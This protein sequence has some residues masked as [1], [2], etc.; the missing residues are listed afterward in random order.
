[1]PSGELRDDELSPATVTWTE[2]HS[3]TGW[4]VWLDEY[5]DE[6]SMF[7]G[8]FPPTAA[9]LRRMQMIEQSELD[10][11]APCAVCGLDVATGVG[12]RIDEEHVEVRAALTSDGP[13]HLECLSDQCRRCGRFVG[14]SFHHGLVAIFAR[15]ALV[16]R[17]CGFTWFPVQAVSD[18]VAR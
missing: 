8:E 18:G 16:Y 10:E 3:G 15:R 1:M 9:E 4:Y 17:C 12:E 5:P 14:P 6:G 11:P 13:V 2:G 7:W